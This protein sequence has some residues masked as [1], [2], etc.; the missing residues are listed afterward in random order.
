MKLYGIAAIAAAFALGSAAQAGNLVTNGGFE[1]NGGN[2]QIGVNTSATGWSLGDTTIPS[3]AFLYGPGTADHGGANGQ[4]G[5][6]ALWGP[7]NGVANGLTPT[8]PDGGFFLATDPAFQQDA[9]VQTING[10][11]PGAKYTVGFWY[12][13][14]QQKNFDGVTHQQW[15]VSLGSETQ[16]TPLFT[17]A[18]HDFS[19]WKHQDFTFTATSASEVLSFFSNGSPQLPPFALL[20]GVTMTSDVPEPAIWTMMVLGL[21]GL[22]LVVRR[23]RRLGAAIA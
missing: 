21:F 16:S 15:E 11:T 17:L 18:S 10:L 1:S 4:F 19:G 12:G 20:D 23:Q 14:A 9:V 13:F 2:G 6:V 8:S 5:N 3:Y 22:G 7:G